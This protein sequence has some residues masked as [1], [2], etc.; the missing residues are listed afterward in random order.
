M[1]SNVAVSILSGCGLWF[2]YS[3]ISQRHKSSSHLLHCF[4]CAAALSAGAHQIVSV[5][6]IYVC[7]EII[8]RIE[9]LVSI[10]ITDRKRL[11]FL[12]RGNKL[13]PIR[14]YIALFSCFSLVTICDPFSKISIPIRRINIEKNECERE[15]V[16]SF[17]NALVFSHV[18]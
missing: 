16:T 1:Q 18:L 12:E 4:L 11:V 17:E 13:L 14:R 3:L 9:R 15:I 2:V 8:N 7:S 5:P 10:I 6:K